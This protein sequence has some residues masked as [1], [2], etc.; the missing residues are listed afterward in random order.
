MQMIYKILIVVTSLFLIVGCKTKP[1]N[2]ATDLKF[3]DSLLNKINSPELKAISKKI[4]EEVNKPELYN[5]RAKL[6]IQLGLAEE[7]EKDANRA[8]KLD[9]L[10]PDYFLTKADALFSANKTKLAKDELELI[11]KNSLPIQKHY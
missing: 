5:E 7:A 6:Y 8:I 2:D 3:Q 9:S 4:T 1:D 10:K 11:E